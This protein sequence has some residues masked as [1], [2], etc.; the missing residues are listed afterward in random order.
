MALDY[1]TSSVNSIQI[2][3]C[4]Y[5]LLTDPSDFVVITFLK[6]GVGSALSSKKKRLGWK[7]SVTRRACASVEGGAEQP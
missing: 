1:N 7:G 5:L 2:K 6:T 3:V 4:V